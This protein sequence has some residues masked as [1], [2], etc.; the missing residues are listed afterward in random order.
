MADNYPLQFQAWETRDQG[1]PLHLQRSSSHHVRKIKTEG[2]GGGGRGKGGTAEERGGG[3]GGIGR[4]E[5][6]GGRG[7]GRGGG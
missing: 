2:G 7:G 4:V 1:A 6:R 5:K 3:R